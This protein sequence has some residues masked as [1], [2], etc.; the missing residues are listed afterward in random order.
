MAVLF[1]DLGRI[2]AGKG[3]SQRSAEMARKFLEKK[4]YEQR[5]IEE[6]VYCVLVHEHPWQNKAGLIQTIEAKVVFDADMIQQLSKFGIIKASIEFQNILKRDYKEGV[7][8]ARDNEFSKYNMLL[9]ENGR[10]M[11]EKGYKYI[12][13][14]FNELL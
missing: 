7:I 1:H 2:K 4:D 5:F 12:K 9:T 8:S 10:K 11:A 3:H 14:F 6:V 13:D